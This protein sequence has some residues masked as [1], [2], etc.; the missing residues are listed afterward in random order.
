MEEALGWQHLVEPR[1][2]FQ[3][4]AAHCLGERPG[5]TARRLNASRDTLRRWRQRALGQIVLKLNERA[6][7]SR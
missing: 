5:I 4:L 1:R 6:G 3:A 7:G 2:H